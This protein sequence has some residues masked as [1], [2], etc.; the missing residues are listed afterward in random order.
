MWPRPFSSR[1]ERVVRH[2]HAEGV[3]ETLC[4]MLKRGEARSFC[5]SR[6]PHQQTH[7][8]RLSTPFPPPK[9]PAQACRFTLTTRRPSPPH[10]PSS[11][12]SHRHPSTSPLRPKMPRSTCRAS[13]GTSAPRPANRHAASARNSPPALIPVQY[14]AFPIH[15]FSR[16]CGSA[17]LEVLP[18]QRKG[19]R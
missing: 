16:R 15:H 4:L 10:R 18:Y 19:S 14:R 2:P 5:I 9:T 6:C 3:D 13:A 7:C 1:A 17:R 8:C 12:R 11:L